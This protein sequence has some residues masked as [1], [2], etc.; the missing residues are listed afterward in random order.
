MRY[1]N[2]PASH[3]DSGPVF[4]DRSKA[5]RGRMLSGECPPGFSL[6]TGQFT[7]AVTER[8][9]LDTHPPKYAQVEVC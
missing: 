2:G 5:Y 3:A 6:Q 9:G 1:A 4:V 8:V 7:R